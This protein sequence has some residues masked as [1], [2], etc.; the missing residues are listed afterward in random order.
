MVAD[1][2]PVVVTVHGGREPAEAGFLVEARE[3]VG[4]FEAVHGELL[5]QLGDEVGPRGGRQPGPRADAAQAGAQ[6]ACFEGGEVAERD[7]A[8][9]LGRRIGA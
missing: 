8:R 4:V 1:A 6:T 7:G 3:L 9:A 2:Q 5:R